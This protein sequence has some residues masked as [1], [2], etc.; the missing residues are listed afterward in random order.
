M[1]LELSEAVGMVRRLLKQ[2]GQILMRRWSSARPLALKDCRDFSTALDLE[3]EGNLK[4]QLGE[5]FPEH[6][7]SGEE[8][9]PE[10]SQADYQW[11]VDPIDGTK[12]FAAQASLFSISVGLS[13]RGDPILGVVH[14]PPSGQ[15]FYAWRGGGAFLDD[16]ALRGSKIT[17]LSRAIV[18]V[19]TPGSH[20]LQGQ[21]REWF[22]SKLIEL[23][24]SC[25][26]IRAL[27]QGS[28]ATCW[29]AC[30]ALD[31]YIDLTGRTKPQDLA[32]GRVIAQESG[33]RV[34]EFQPPFGPARLL[35]APTAL[36]EE[37]ERLLR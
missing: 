10:N 31:A 30:G 15:C 33:M 32:A 6:G 5:R 37:L 18:N 19:E 1:A 8:S 11:L 21:E 23:T 20:E 14:S 12:Y 25:Y 16:R 7:F 36:W 13:F 26:R 9:P 22:E 35:A 28:L 17:E 3:I 24:R 2:Q 29:L 4:S 27:G 34:E